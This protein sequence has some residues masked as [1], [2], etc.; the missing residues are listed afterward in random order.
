MHI[1][2]EQNEVSD[3]FPDTHNHKNKA[4]NFKFILTRI[5]SYIALARDA[6]QSNL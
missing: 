1:C 4:G 3:V 2:F 5:K 6:F